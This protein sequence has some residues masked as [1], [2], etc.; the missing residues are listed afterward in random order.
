MD[1][2]S[3]YADKLYISDALWRQ[4][5]EDAGYFFIDKT[6]SNIRGIAKNYIVPLFGDYTPNAL[7]PK[8]IKNSLKTVS[9]SGGAKN[10]II[11]YL[12]NIYRY[13]IEEDIFNENPTTGVIRYSRKQKTERGIISDEEMAMLF[14]ESHD[15]RLNIWRTQ[16]YLCAFMVLRDTGLRPGEL[17]ALK[18]SDWYHDDLFFPITKAIEAGTRNKIKNTKTGIHRPAIVTPDTAKEIEVLRKMAKKVPDNFIFAGIK[19][20]IPYDTHRLCYALR[21]ALSKA[22]INKPEYTPYWFRHTFNTKSLAEFPDEKVRQLMGHK[23][24]KMTQHYNHPDIAILKKEAK[25]LHA[26]IK[27]KGLKNDLL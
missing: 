15:E 22:G 20:N 14:P 11:R 23:T 25:K 17:A 13:L 8:I 12:S 24:R 9:L 4:R 3:Y 7:R 21:L 1:K 5:I 19:N 2:I 27:E 26:I 18:W 10:K 16:R 6:Y